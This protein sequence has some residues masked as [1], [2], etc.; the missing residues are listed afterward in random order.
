MT[1]RV[2]TDINCKP[3]GELKIVLLSCSEV[4]LRV[5]SDISL[6]YFSMLIFRRFLSSPRSKFISHSLRNLELNEVFWTMEDELFLKFFGKMFEILG[7][8]RRIV[9]LSLPA[10]R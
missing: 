5:S 1:K 6:Q 7:V 9:C 2:I 8:K 4:L 3:F 10:G